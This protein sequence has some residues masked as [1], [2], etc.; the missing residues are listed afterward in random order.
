[1]E[2]QLEIQK[3]INHRLTGKTFVVTGATS[4]IGLAAAETLA[5][6]GAM[7]IGIGRSKERCQ[8]AERRLRALFPG[9]PTVLITADLAL[10]SEVAPPLPEFAASWLREKHPRSTD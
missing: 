5:G 7:V 6:E 9:C 3:P 1:M 8:Q 4:G 10:Q 2:T